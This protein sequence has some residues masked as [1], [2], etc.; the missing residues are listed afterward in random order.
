MFQTKEQ[1]KT[2]EKQLNETEISNLLDKEWKVMVIKIP[3]DLRRMEEHTEN[4]NR[5]RQNIK[6][7]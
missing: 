4:F 3:A 7:N 1:D 2:S 5:E 6:K